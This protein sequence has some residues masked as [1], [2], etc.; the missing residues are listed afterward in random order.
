MLKPKVFHIHKR[1]GKPLHPFSRYRQANKLTMKELGA[2]LEITESM[3]SKI[4]AWETGISK[5]LCLKAHLTTGG[6]INRDELAWP[7]LYE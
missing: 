4:E 7:E 1:E 5:A 6:N 3:V 2:L